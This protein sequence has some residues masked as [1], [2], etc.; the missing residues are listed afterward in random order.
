M[1]IHE[2]TDE[3]YFFSG[4]L[5]ITLEG[6]FC[7]CRNQLDIHQQKRFFSGVWGGCQLKLWKHRSFL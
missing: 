4:V 1:Q 5:F 7:F 2:D 6:M 3:R